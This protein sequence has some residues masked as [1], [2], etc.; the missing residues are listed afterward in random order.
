MK[1][2]RV[3][4]NQPLMAHYQPAEITKPR[5]SSFNYPSPLVSSH[6]SPILVC[7]F[8]VIAASR[9]DRLNAS[10][11]ER[12]AKR[13]RVI[14][15]VCNKSVRMLPRSARSIAPLNSYSIYRLLRQFHFRRRGRLQ[16]CSQPSTR[17]ID[18]N[19]PL[20]AFAALGLTDFRSPFLADSKLPSAKHS[21]Q[22]ILS[23]SLSCA[24]RPRHIFSRTPLSSHS[25]NLRQQVEELPYRLGNSLHCAPVHRIHKMPSKQRR[26]SAR[27]LPP[28]GL[29][30]CCGR[31]A[32]IFSHCLSVNCLHAMLSKNHSSFPLARRF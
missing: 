8:F 15:S 13:I 25:R 19:H 32:L 11:L 3:S 10:L 6:L 23:R 29:G 28:F 31:Y 27:G 21:S 16:E 1:E 26:S 4:F 9:D 14:S 12:F 30:L 2:T 5:K 17:A 22:R 24:K 7:R 20:C 18:R